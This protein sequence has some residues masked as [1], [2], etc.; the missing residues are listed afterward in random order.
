MCF[1]MYFHMYF[2]NGFAVLVEDRV[3]AHANGWRH[4]H[5]PRPQQ[6]TQPVWSRAAATCTYRV[7]AAGRGGRALGLREGPGERV[8]VQHAHQDVRWGCLVLALL[9]ALLCSLYE[10]S[11][12]SAVATTHNSRWC[13]HTQ[14]LARPPAGQWHTLTWP[15]MTYSLP[16]QRVTVWPALGASAGAAEAARGVFSSAS[17][18]PSSAL[19]V[20]W[21][22]RSC[23]RSKTHTSLR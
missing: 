16:F 2:H 14:W 4:P 22:Q 3:H 1:Y 5:Q 11:H 21:I 15:P 12:T 8:G 23:D 6:G 13:D 9:R 18:A 7:A 19:R 17:S 10:H 20:V